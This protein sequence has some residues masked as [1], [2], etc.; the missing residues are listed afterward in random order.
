[1]VA[2][3]TYEWRDDAANEEGNHIGPSRQC[4]VAFQ[5]NNQAEEEADNEH[6]HIPPPRRFLVMLDHVIVVT[7]VE[8]TFASTRVSRDDILTPENDHMGYKCAD[9]EI[10][11]EHCG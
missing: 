4:D 3:I 7:V 10:L 8:H 9:L 11:S 5:H 2:G 6:N 1:M